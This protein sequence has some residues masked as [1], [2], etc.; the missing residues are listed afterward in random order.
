MKPF[1]CWKTGALFEDADITSAERRKA[2]L[3]WL[4]VVDYQSNFTNNLSLC[5]PGTG[6]WFIESISCCQWLQPSSDTR[7]N[8]WLSGQG[9]Y[10]WFYSGEKRG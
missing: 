1:V 5:E 7:R 8:L 10:C 4:A 6:K 3:K 9:L 2:V